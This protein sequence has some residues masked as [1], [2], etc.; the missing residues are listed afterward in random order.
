M[1]RVAIPSR[2]RRHVLVSPGMLQ[3]NLDR[4]SFELAQWCSDLE[5]N[6]CRDSANAET[7]LGQY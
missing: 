1:V 5:F 4:F 3:R 7:L 6:E 2:P